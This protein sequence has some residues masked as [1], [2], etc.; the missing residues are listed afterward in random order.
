M[1]EIR[2]SILSWK[3]QEMTAVTTSPPADI[4]LIARAARKK[5]RGPEDWTRADNKS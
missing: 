5:W 1:V 3:M 4:T 2:G